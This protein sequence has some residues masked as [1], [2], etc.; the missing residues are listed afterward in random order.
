M[1]K[2]ITSILVLMSILC[3]SANAEIIIDYNS[4]KLELDVAPVCENDIV[5]IPL[6]AVFEKYGLSVSWDAET[7]TVFAMSMDKV[8]M[9]QIGNTSAFVDS[10]EIQLETAPVI[11]KDRTMVSQSFIEAALGVKTVWHESAQVIEITAE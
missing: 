6:R 4:E 10:E 1:K 3:M 9:V 11:V 7:S 8:V 5:M 2:F